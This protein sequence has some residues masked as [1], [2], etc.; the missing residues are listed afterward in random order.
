MPVTITREEY[1]AADLRRAA[2]R[3][4]D[5][6]AARRML[7]LALVLEGKSRTEAARSCGMDRQ[8]LR[9]WVHRYNAEGLPGLADRP[10]PGRTP[11]L[12]PAQMAELEA[13]VETGPDPATDGVVRWRR[14][15]LQA[16]IAARFGVAVH[17]RTVGKLLHKLD[18]AKLSVRPQHPQADPEAQAAFKKTSMTW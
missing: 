10:H 9:D 15:D 3:T 13:I 12:S 11:R 14:I 18:F 5:A 8:T 17:E 16:V 2:A 4:R 1:G 6:A 7:A